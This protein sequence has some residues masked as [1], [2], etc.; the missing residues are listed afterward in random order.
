MSNK[1]ILMLVSIWVL[2]VSYTVSAQ[3]QDQNVDASEV[4]IVLERL[5]S[6]MQAGDFE[7]IGEIYA[8]ERSVHIIEGAGV[9]HGWEEYRDD[10]L[11]PEFAAFSN[12]NIVICNRAPS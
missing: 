7:A 9:N 11:R 6:L 10:H 1:Y 3:E 8:P 4:R 5:A 2:V 12:L